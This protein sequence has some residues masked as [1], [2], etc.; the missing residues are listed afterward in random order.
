M[1][2][3]V[4]V[5]G[6]VVGVGGVGGVGCGRELMGVW[7]CGGDAVGWRRGFGNGGDVA[8]GRLVWGGLL[9]AHEWMPPAI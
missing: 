7:R 1:W 6:V 4:A 5:I 8:G 2:L 9:V 3:V